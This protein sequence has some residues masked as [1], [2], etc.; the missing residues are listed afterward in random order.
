MTKLRQGFGQLAS[1]QIGQIS[2]V[3]SSQLNEQSE[4]IND[5]VCLL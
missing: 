1:S 3:M 4:R 5:M 2:E